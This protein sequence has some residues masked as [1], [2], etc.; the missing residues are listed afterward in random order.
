MRA[1][2]TPVRSAPRFHMV[3]M[4][5][6]AT[7]S[8]AHE[9]LTARERLLSTTPPVTFDKDSI[10]VGP[11]LEFHRRLPVAFATGGR[12]C[13]NFR[14][15]QYGDMADAARCGRAARHSSPA[16]YEVG[17]GLDGANRRSGWFSCCARTG[18]ALL[19]W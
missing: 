15:N 2:G 16:P 8:L 5:S 7:C 19:E 10:A 14:I 9:H 12:G 11:F 6:Q 1:I 18:F 13:Q 17:P 4:G 3:S